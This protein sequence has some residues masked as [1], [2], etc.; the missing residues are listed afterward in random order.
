MQEKSDR[1]AKRIISDGHSIEFSK[2][3]AT[4]MGMSF[5]GE[6]EGMW[7][8]GNS[9]SVQSVRDGLGMESADIN[10]ADVDWIRLG[11]ENG[12]MGSAYT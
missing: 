8:D 7:G 12:R 9:R 2:E 10:E 11:G 4:S 5:C 1:W 3:V 6:G